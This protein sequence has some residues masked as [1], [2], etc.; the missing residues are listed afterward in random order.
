[1]VVKYTRLGAR[2]N[3]KYWATEDSSSF[4]KDGPV[5]LALSYLVSYMQASITPRLSLNSV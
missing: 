4:G 1:M 5:R 2:M 3:A